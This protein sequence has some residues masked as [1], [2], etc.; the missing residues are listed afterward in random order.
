[1]VS[2]IKYLSVKKVEL[3]KSMS[4][5]VLVSMMLVLILIASKPSI[6]LLTIALLY[7]ASGPALFLYRHYR[8]VETEA[9]ALSEEETDDQKIISL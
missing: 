7:I 3:K 8:K 4:F 9:E 2:T 5:N 6:T 1:M